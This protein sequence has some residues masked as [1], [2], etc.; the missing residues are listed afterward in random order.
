MTL[1][2]RLLRIYRFFLAR[3]YLYKINYH[4]YKLSL[5]AIGILNSEGGGVTGEDYLLRSLKNLLPIKT[6][7]DVGAND[8][9]YSTSLRKFF[10]KATIYAFEPHPQSFQRLSRISNKYN[11]KVFRLGLGNKITKGKIWDFADDAKLKHTQPTSTLASIYKEVIE[12]YHRQKAQ[13]FD[14][15]LTTLDDFTS[16]Q[17][18]KKIDFLKIDTEG[19]EYN[20]LLGARNLLKERKIS[21]IQFEFNEMNVYSRRF[22]KD[23]VDLLSGYEF[24][25]LLPNGLIKLGPYRPLEFEIFAF[26]NI[27]AVP[28]KFGNKVSK[29]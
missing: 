12:G 14:I 3:K 23:Y 26:Q 1:K 29:L 11:I 13:S 6:I 2:I 21:V 25:R 5:R 28:M 9:G 22:F 20:V 19:S 7:F 10:P 15:E 27:L 4:L 24:Y 18:I 17:N 16:K 8:G